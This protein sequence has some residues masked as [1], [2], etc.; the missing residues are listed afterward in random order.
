MPVLIVH[1]IDDHTVPMSIGRSL[2]GKVTTRKFLLETDGG[3]FNAGMNE[4]SKLKRAFMQ[5]WPD[6]LSSS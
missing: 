6:S 5:L 4:L 2:Y 3:H 1:A